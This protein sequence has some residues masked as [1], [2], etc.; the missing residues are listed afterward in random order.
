MLRGALEQLSDADQE[1][2]ANEALTRELT[3]PEVHQ[4]VAVS[5][6]PSLCE[7]LGR[8][9]DCVTPAELQ[10]ALWQQSFV[11]NPTHA[12]DHRNYRRFA[13]L[14]AQM[15]AIGVELE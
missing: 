8:L 5:A 9:P 12:P 15:V 7:L 14:A 2:F 1:S 10:E 11:E 6:W 13:L 4:S 3:K